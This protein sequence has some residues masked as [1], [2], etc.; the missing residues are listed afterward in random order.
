V[1]VLVYVLDALRTD[2]CSCYGYDRETTPTIDGL[3]AD[4]VRFEQ[5]LTPATWTRPVAGTLATGLYPPAH[6]TRT[7]KDTFDPPRPA[8]AE[9]FAAADFETVGVTAM[10]NVSSA[11]GFDRG[12]DRFF[13]LYKDYD[14]IAKRDTST[15]TDEELKS[16]SGTVALPRAEDVTDAL[17][18][19][20]ADRT[21]NRP[22]FAFCWSIEPHIPYDPP[23]G[24]DRFRA[25][26]YDGPVDGSRDCLKGVESEAD[27]EQ[28]KALYDEEIRYNDEC[29]DDL[30][31]HL[32]NAGE[33]E[34]TLVVVV[35]DHGDA[36]E[37]H[38][39]L[40]HGHSPHEELVRVPWVVRTP[41]ET[42]GHVVS[43][44]V[45]LVDLYATV[46]NA[47]TEL[48]VPQPN[49]IAGHSVAPAFD[50]DP[51]S[52]HDRVFF[53]TTSYDMQSSFY[54]VRTP[55]WKYI[56]VD[57]PDTDASTFVDLAT[58]VMEKGIVLDILRNPSYYW[59]RYRYDETEQLY[60]LAVDPTES[61][62]LNRNEPG[63]RDELERVLT[64]WRKACERYR[65]RAATGDGEEAIDDR[66]KEQLRQLGYTE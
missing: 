40:T 17:G 31:D 60:H 45:S 66:T 58:Y 39:R 33:Y 1:N 52:G 42:A 64:K 34:D 41:D 11:T 35:G 57:T 4:G 14:I 28:L 29:I 38:G 16:E 62:N 55:D 51:V 7:R 27:V 32:R 26:D 8:L 23:E 19:W 53:E 46:L 2:H 22:F 44:Q 10:G 61:E 48:D 63:R 24:Y 21:N 3:A 59:R 13:D 43:E 36:F 65:E 9:Q 30:L 12:F 37:E 20:I 54:G 47:A 49:P 5:C 18:E 56:E 25:P 6:G 15:A 50:G